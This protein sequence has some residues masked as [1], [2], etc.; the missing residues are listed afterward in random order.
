MIQSL[1]R[2]GASDDLG[3][4]HSTFMVE[5]LETATILKEATDQSLVILDEVGRGTSTYDGVSIAWAVAG[6]SMSRC[7]VWQCLP[8]YHEL[9]DLEVGHG[10]HYQC[11][12][13]GSAE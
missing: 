10:S 4:G 12:C 5:M 2:V 6:L 3:H 7:S 11:K 13:G 8:F 1:L 9:T